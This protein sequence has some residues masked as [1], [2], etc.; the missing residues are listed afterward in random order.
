[1]KLN[2][3]HVDIPE[4]TTDFLKEGNLIIG[5]YKEKA[6]N[7]VVEI[8]LLTMRL[9]KQIKIKSP[10]YE[11]DKSIL[12][13]Y[14]EDT[15][16]I[17]FECPVNSLLVNRQITFMRGWKQ[18]ESCIK[19]FNGLGL[20]AEQVS[21]ELKRLNGFSVDELNK[22]KIRFLATRKNG[23]KLVFSAEEIQVI[24]KEEFT[25]I[26]KIDLAIWN[27]FSSRTIVCSTS[28]NMG[29]SL[30]DALRYMQNNEIDAFGKKIQILNKDEGSLVI[31]CPDESADFMNQEKTIFL[32]G[33]EA[34]MPP[35]TKLRTYIN[36]IQRDPGALRDAL[37]CGGYFFP[38]NPQS[39]D[40][41]QNLLF[42]SL[43]QMMEERNCKFE[44]LLKDD[45]I[46]D[47]LVSLRCKIEDNKV[48]VMDGIEGGIAGL[49]LPYFL[50]LEEIVPNQGLKAIVT[51]NQASI[52]AALA[53]AI[54]AD[55]VVRNPSCL[56][57]HVR[58][59]FNNL[60]P[61]ISKFLDNKKIGKDIQTRIHGVFDLANLQ[62]LAQLLGVVVEKHL[63]GRGTAYVGLGSSS[64]SNGNRCYE[65]LKDSMEK[66][67]SFRGK[68]T[69]HP[70]THTINPFAQALIYLEDVFRVYQHPIFKTLNKEQKIEWVKKHTRKPE[71]AG[72][73]AYAGYL[74]SRLDTGTLSIVEIAYV[75]KLM[76]FSKIHFLDFC[77]LNTDDSGENKFLQES[78]EEGHFMG[79]MARNI[80]LMLD[81]PL[82]Y[83]EKKV[84]IERNYSKLKYK[85]Y[86]LDDASVDNYN[87]IVNIYL[88][89]DNTLQPNSKFIKHLLEQIEKNE[90]K[91]ATLMSEYTNGVKNK[92]ENDIISFTSRFLNKVSEKLKN[93]DT[94]IH[95]LMRKTLNNMVERK[96]KKIY[97]NEDF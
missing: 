41:I 15:D 93:L 74:L 97:Q 77:N 87:P 16:N 47:T 65:I 89:G 54:L 42:F 18:F 83:I 30:H 3:I 80:L 56:N 71:H 62:S 81:W 29:I 70:A 72:A 90:I 84:N 79:D 32:K 63:S 45:K 58:S 49:A 67:T 75:L 34:E 55:N 8:T 64:Y 20:M 50:M 14:S 5:N 60:F 78:S 9:A 86:S 73:A 61:N 12:L 19:G 17:I 92:R 24:P 21:M 38:T 35:L 68:S 52:G 10:H 31:W 33:L 2:Y 37:L 22:N 66:N 69:F 53:A 36:R 48:I 91:L 76:G 96:V 85:L 27:C 25:R 28:S 44:D 46:L 51:W 94:I 59:E 82:D 95:L 11:S 88:T 6:L 26:N 13:P 57:E 40:E 39:I 23:G 7:D 1:M 4:I 43:D